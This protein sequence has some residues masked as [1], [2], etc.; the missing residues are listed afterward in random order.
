MTLIYFLVETSN[1]RSDMS[2]K[3]ARSHLEVTRSGFVEMEMNSFLTH[4]LHHVRGNR[5]CDRL[6]RN[7]LKCVFARY[8]RLCLDH[9][10]LSKASYFLSFSSEALIF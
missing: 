3:R 9:H 5:L 4:M 10:F 2:P 7:F 8:V 1:T 6:R